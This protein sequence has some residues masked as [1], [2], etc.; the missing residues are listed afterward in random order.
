MIIARNFR[1]VT[2]STQA[3]AECDLIGPDMPDRLS[4]SVD[5]GH[6]DA[7]DV[8]E[9]NWAAMTLLYP[10]MLMGHDLVIESDVSAL[11]L[12]NMR[13][14]LMALIRNFEPLA[15]PIKIEAGQS[16]R[17][18][19]DAGRE[20]MSG[21]SAGVDSF[22][23]LTK[24]TDP[25]LHPDLRLTALG[26]FH[27]GAL[28]SPRDS[29]LLAT[30]LD[31]IRPIARDH[32][33][34]L[35]SLTSDIGPVFKAAKPFGPVDFSK[36]VG[37]RNAAAALALQKGV[38]TYMTAGNRSYRTATYG[39]TT[40]TERMDPV[41]QPLLGTES[42]RMVPAVA[43]L[44]RFEKVCFLADRA[45]PRRYLNP[46]V[47][48]QDRRPSNGVLNCS[49]CWK[50]TQT[51]LDLEVAGKLDA[52][53][54]VFDV[55]HYRTNRSVLLTNLMNKARYDWGERSL[56]IF[57]H[58]VE[59]GVSLPSPDRPVIYWTRDFFRRGWSKAKR[60][61]RAYLG[62]TNAGM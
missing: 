22:T 49:A 40:T 34:K 17:R 36:T 23:T 27:V 35:Y 28:G 11:L 48:Q 10:A 7:L 61:L 52:F 13:N 51:M 6:A 15:K 21:F 55:A 56:E 43:G 47:V 33:L 45:A 60:G 1:I 18:L 24:F 29:S 59:A 12:N 4:F 39:R 31:L 3:S 20:V 46:C 57:E 16:S 42:L 53:A 9:P 41:F 54:G 58:V 37:F 14:D 50:C 32:G 62:L 26:T 19:S 5:L 8:D 2:T 38:Q 25:Q 44:S 30:A